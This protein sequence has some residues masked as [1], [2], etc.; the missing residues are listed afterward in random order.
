MPPVAPKMT[1]VGHGD[2]G[3][4]H[5]GG[6]DIQRTIACDQQRGEAAS[7]AAAGKRKGVGASCCGRDGRAA[8]VDAV[9][10]LAGLDYV[11]P[12]A[13]AVGLLGVWQHMAR[14]R[15]GRSSRRRSGLSRWVWS[16]CLLRLLTG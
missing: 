15:V 3:V 6:L 11:V 16:A 10:Q 1:L 13:F 7:L 14:C 4:G 12:G 8:G 2:C 9:D 5:A